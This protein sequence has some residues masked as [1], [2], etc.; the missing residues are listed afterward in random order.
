LLRIAIG[1]LLL[2]DVLVWM[3]DLQAWFGPN[4]A[5]NLA[6]CRLVIDPNTMT[7][8]QWLPQ[9]ETSVLIVYVLMLIQIVALIL[10]CYGRVQAFFIFVWLVSFNHRNNLIFDAEDNLLR[11]WTFFLIFMPLDAAFSIRKHSPA[12]LRREFPIWPLRLLQL[13][14]CLVYLSASLL[15]LQ[16]VEWRDGTAV[17]YALNARQFFHYPIPDFVRSSPGIILILTWTVMTFELV[18]PFGL[19]IPKIRR[20]FLVLGLLLHLGMEYSLNL[21]LF[22]W[23]MMVGLCTF[24]KREDV[25]LLLR[26]VS[27]FPRLQIT[28]R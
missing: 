9:T 15:K 12:S 14:L 17:Y 25:H 27:R 13:Q 24:V 1:L 16:G 7:V 6:A 2:V 23:L 18:L 8:F 3:P 19:W 22:Q 20:L 28:K 10:G 26:L 21:F 5:H 4:G 11:L